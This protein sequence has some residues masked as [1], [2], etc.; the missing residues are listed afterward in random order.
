[1]G[2]VLLKGQPYSTYLAE[3]RDEHNW[4]QNKSICQES[5][6]TCDQNLGEILFVCAVLRPCS[7]GRAWGCM[8]QREPVKSPDCKSPQ[9]F[10]HSSSRQW[11]QPLQRIIQ[12][13][14]IL[15]QRHMCVFAQSVCM[16]CGFTWISSSWH[17]WAKASFSAKSSVRSSKAF[18]SWEHEEI[19]KWLML[20]LKHKQRL[21]F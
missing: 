1:M 21:F 6:W 11:N 12:L 9:S 5:S 16:H 14:F 13:L 10:C 7:S 8:P 15:Y 3:T 4:G 18:F 17:R 19:A 2:L 20:T